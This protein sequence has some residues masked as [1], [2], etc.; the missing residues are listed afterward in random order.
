MVERGTR[1][2]QCVRATRTEPAG[3]IGFSALLFAI[4]LVAAVSRS[5]LIVFGPCCS[6][7]NDAT[8]DRTRIARN[9]AARHPRLSFARRHMQTKE[10]ILHEMQSHQGQL[11][12]QY[13][14]DFAC[15]GRI[16]K[17]SEQPTEDQ[18]KI[19]KNDPKKEVN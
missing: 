3:S 4:L 15:C 1:I 17:L 19:V 18:R 9:G 7:L 8:V 13:G 2:T 12:Q 10:L 6:Q 16:R 14:S 5:G 11:E